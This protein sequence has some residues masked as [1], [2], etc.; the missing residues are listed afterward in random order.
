M[1]KKL[2]NYSGPKVLWFL[3]LFLVFSLILAPQ[4]MFPHKASAD[5]T[6]SDDFN[7]ADGGLGPNW[8]AISDGGMAIASQQVTGTSG[9][10]AGDMWAADT[11]TSDQFSS[12]EVTSTQLSGGQWVGPAVRLQNNGLDGYLGIYFWN[13][14]SPV[15]MLYKRSGGSWAELG[16]TYNIGALA[17]GTQL[18]LTAVGGRI[19]F[20]VNGV[21]YL[22]AADTSLTGGA[23]GMIQHHGLK[24]FRF[25]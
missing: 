24:P 21:Q 22:S 6:A 3:R 10:T 4:F 23:P 8:T 1:T 20:L 9:G 7:R 11:F 19:S 12:V 5:V 18:E 17:A 25:A 15:L 14:G 2:I 13:S 16:G